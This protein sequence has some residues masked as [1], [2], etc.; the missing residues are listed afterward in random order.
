MIGT[1]SVQEGNGASG[2]FTLT[3]LAATL[4]ALALLALVLLPSAFGSNREG[5][6]HA[7]CRNN[8][9]QLAQA[10]FMYGNDYQDAFPASASHG[11]GAQS[12]DWVYWQLSGFG[13]GGFFPRV[14]NQS[15]V[16]RYLP[17]FSPKSLRCPSDT[18]ALQRPYIYSYSLNGFRLEGMASWID[19]A[20]ATIQINGHGSIVDPARKIM[21]AEE[22]GSPS[23]GPPAG[24]FSNDGRWVA[25]SNPVTQRHE[26]Q[27]NVGFADGR[28]E[29]V[30]R[31]FALQR[32]NSDPTL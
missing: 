10:F 16:A 22:K 23:D 32:E 21:L 20:W 9:R 3:E 8:L 13:P 2:G 6:R 4:A 11:L 15:R 17:A 1:W 31:E 12:E 19:R 29:T 25:P 14:L 27:G 7:Q 5:G 18:V 26:G 24:T 30:T 28:V